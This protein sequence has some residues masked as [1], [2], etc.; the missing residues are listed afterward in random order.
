MDKEEK[1]VLVMS[2]V[3][4]IAVFAWR[5]M[6]NPPKV[7]VGGIRVHHGLVGAGMFV[8]GILSKRPH[9]AILGLIL[10]LDD[11]EDASEWLNLT[12]S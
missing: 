10:A 9:L 7:R 2:L 6:S 1:L 8:L 4:L 12:E 3:A 5:S 11:I